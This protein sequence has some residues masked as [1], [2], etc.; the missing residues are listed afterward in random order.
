MN[1]QVGHPVC[2]MTVSTWNT[3]LDMTVSALLEA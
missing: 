1:L 2:I 3:Q